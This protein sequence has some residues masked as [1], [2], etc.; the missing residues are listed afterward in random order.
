M[1]YMDYWNLY[2]SVWNFHKKYAD[3]KGTDSYWEAVVNESRQIAN[4][5][6]NHEFVLALLV[7]VINELEHICKGGAKNADAAV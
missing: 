1:N 7:A 3:A 5:Y 6:G 2:K 4:Q